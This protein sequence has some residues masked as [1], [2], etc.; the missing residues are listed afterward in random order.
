[1]LPQGAFCHRHAVRVERRGTVPGNEPTTSI[2]L[3]SHLQSYS[4]IRANRIDHSAQCVKLCASRSL[5]TSQHLSIEIA[6][7]SNFLLQTQMTNDVILTFAYQSGC[8]MCDFLSLTFCQ[9]LFFF[10]L[11]VSGSGALCGVDA[12]TVAGPLVCV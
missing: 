10:L 11:F 8:Q 6:F 5:N 4:I 9:V 1:M 2:Y 7:L 12:F 3:D